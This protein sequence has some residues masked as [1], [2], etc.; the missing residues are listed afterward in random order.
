M[1]AS[2]CS[3]C[4]RR[5]RNAVFCPVCGTALCSWGCCRT[6]HVQHHLGAGLKRDEAKVNDPSYP[7]RHADEKPHV[8]LA[9]SCV[10]REP[11]S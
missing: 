6:H 4:G 10:L 3:L 2:K 11:S 8:R 7:A 9:G 5:L 1:N